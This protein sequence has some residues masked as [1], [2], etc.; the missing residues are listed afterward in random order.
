MRPPTPA[1]GAG[2]VLYSLLS[3]LATTQQFIKLLGSLHPRQ[4]GLGPWRQA[5]E[6]GP[7]AG[8]GWR[9]PPDAAALAL[10]DVLATC[11][12]SIGGAFGDGLLDVL[13]GAKPAP[14]D[15][16]RAEATALLRAILKGTE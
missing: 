1:P 11:L 14:G 13:A 12:F 6:A 15:V 16:G 2:R 10:Q 8:L 3:A 4:A 9:D 7:A 5:A